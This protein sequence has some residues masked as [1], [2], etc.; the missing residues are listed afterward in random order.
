[1]KYFCKEKIIDNYKEICRP[2]TKL[3]FHFTSHKR[4]FVTIV[5]VKALCSFPTSADS[6]IGQDRSEGWK[7]IMENVIISQMGNL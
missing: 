2:F 1:M 7:V 6:C 3:K 5:T 4:E